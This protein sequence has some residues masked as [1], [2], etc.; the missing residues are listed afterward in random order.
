MT[1]L[2]SKFVRDT[3]IFGISSM[4]SKILSYLI[5]V[6]VSRHLGAEGLGQYSFIF[7][8]IAFFFLFSDMGL[9]RLLIKDVAKDSS[10]AQQYVNNIFGFKLVSLSITLG[11]YLSVIPFIGKETILS[12]LVL[13][14]IWI[15]LENMNKLPRSLLRTKHESKSISFSLIIERSLA[16]L[17]A[18]LLLP[19]TQSLFT[20]ILILVIAKAIE[21]GYLFLQ[22]FRYVQLRAAF[23]R[24]IL[25]KL[26]SQSYPF[27]LFALFTT[28]YVK[29]DTVMLSFIAGD[30]VT[31]W[32]NAPYKMINVLNIVPS[33][34]LAF[35]FPK[36]AHLYETNKKSFRNVLEAMIRVSF[37]IITPIIIGVF[38]V[39][40]RVLDFVYDFSP[41]ESVIA[42]QILIFV[43]IFVFL[44]F[45]I[46]NAIASHDQKKFALFAGIGAGVNI[47]LNFLLIPQFSLYGAAV[48][49]LLTYIIIFILMA[50][51]LKREMTN[52]AFVKWMISPLL[53]TAVM[54]PVLIQ[55]QE[56][57][58]LFVIPLTGVV[59]FGV[60]FV[61]Y[62]I[63]KMM[64]QRT[65]A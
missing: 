32:Y 38:V 3:G 57:H 12:A 64:H 22:T 60:Y 29:M 39:G 23:E 14:G 50:H 5:I 45:I 46:G 44:T 27:L 13:G 40:D 42:F 52:I 8:F 24:T 9:S 33:A 11:I 31:G 1:L 62:K 7:S 35:G 54:A 16:L 28:I 51:Y 65:K 48:A 37:I 41:L 15:T 49:T 43:E 63:E 4:I 56:F 26:L 10:K 55:I 36:L 53:A 21:V 2:K 58:L 30:L 20:F 61:L 25:K 59:Y 34:L 6:L 47:I 17:G 19:Y 18:M